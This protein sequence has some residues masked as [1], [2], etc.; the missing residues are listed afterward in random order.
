MIKYWNVSSIGTK[1][2]LYFHASDS[3]KP[4]PQVKKPKVTGWFLSR[5]MWVC[6]QAKTE[7]SVPRVG[8]ACRRGGNER[9]G[10]GGER[11]EIGDGCPTGFKQPPFLSGETTRERWEAS[12]RAE[13]RRELEPMPIMVTFSLG[14]KRSG[15]S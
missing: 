1:F 13:G 14:G 5:E 11:G 9:V 3:L 7:V 8:G 6:F 12:Q 4:R 10:D 15:T 2:R